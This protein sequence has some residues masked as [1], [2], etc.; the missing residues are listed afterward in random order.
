L[1]G[2]CSLQVAKRLNAKHTTE[3]DP[4]AGRIPNL[5][6]VHPI[7][8]ALGSPRA[9]AL[10][11]TAL[12]IACILGTLLPQGSA[13]A[14][15][16]ERLP[17][18]DAWLRAAA[19]VG[20]NHVFSSWWFIGLLF[21]LASGVAVCI[22]CKLA[23]AR[24]AT[25]EDIRRAAASALTHMSLL[26]IFAGGFVRALYGETGLVHLSE[27]ETTAQYLQAS[28]LRPLPFAMR[29]EATTV[30]SEPIAKDLAGATPMVGSAIADVKSTLDITCD[31]GKS[32]AIVGINAPIRVGG[33]RI[34]QV[35]DPRH[36]AAGATLQVVRDPGLP[37][38]YAGFITL[39]GGLLF[40]LYLN[41][42][43]NSRRIVA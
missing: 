13:A 1:I 8:Q 9:A 7:V 18:G 26:L 21:L 28:R 15:H 17:H 20:F 40:N 24:R 32:R 35:T 27:G 2:R 12:V 19:V 37:L 10:V 6:A 30:E 5:P 31:G 39:L 38:V 41:P 16:F 22:G 25:G 3:S 36:A 23:A 4:T 34:Y 43:L 11:T 14:G 33:Y 42:W 29:L